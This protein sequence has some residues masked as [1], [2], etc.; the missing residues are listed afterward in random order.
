MKKLKSIAIL[1]ISFAAFFSCEEELTVIDPSEYFVRF[2][3]TGTS[4]L[5]GSSTIKIP[6]T[7]GSPAQSGSVDITYEISGTAVEG[8]DFQFASTKGTV[9]IPA[10]SYADTIRVQVLDD[11]ESDGAKD[12]ILKLTSVSNGFSAGIGTLGNSYKISIA[13]NDCPF[14]INDY[15]G[16]YT[17]IMEL[18]NGF[19]YAAGTYELDATL[20]LGTSGNTLVDP[21]FGF[22]SGSGRAGVPVTIELDPLGPTTTVLGGNYTFGDGSTATDATYAYGTAPNERVFTG[23]G[24]GTISSCNKEFTVEALIKRQDGTV[25]QVLHLTY[26]KK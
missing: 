25:G 9:T 1:L 8:T 5:E 13:D 24:P 2:Q 19:I 3:S 7:L 20:S 4:L 6:V 15:V 22:L 23:N 26:K 18:E 11:F 17:L 10:G 21:D 16:A 12:I 14:D